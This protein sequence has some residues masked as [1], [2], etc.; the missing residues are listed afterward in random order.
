LK[1]LILFLTLISPILGLLFYYSSCT[2]QYKRLPIY[3]ERTLSESGDTL[4]HTLPP[5]RF[6][7]QNGDTISDQDT[8][9]KFIVGE[10]FFTTCQTICP[11]MARHMETVQKEFAQDDLVILLSH[12]VDPE[13]DS[14]E[15]LKAYSEL[16][17][18]QTGKWHFL[19]GEKKALYDQARYGY[20][21]TALQGDGGPED[22]IHSEKLVL[23]DKDKRIRGFYDGTDT[24]DVKRLID[25]IEVLKFEYGDRVK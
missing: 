9:G 4:Y 17:Q 22:F 11:I 13:R 21:I 2:N 7:N 3:G 16:H 14:V 25:E 12:T 6:V 24:K 18:A 1:K 10:Y 8:E 20:L 15:V 5:F 19:T 23:I